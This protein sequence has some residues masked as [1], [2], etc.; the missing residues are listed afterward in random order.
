MYQFKNMLEMFLI[1]LGD[2]NTLYVSV[3]VV[4]SPPKNCKVT[5]KYIIC[6]SSSHYF[7]LHR[8][9]NIDLNTL[10][11]S[12]QVVEKLDGIITVLFKYIICISSRQLKLYNN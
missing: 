4:I 12:V 11:V 9:F 10:Y 7:C 3:Q 8:S 5:F 6:I 1:N 2:L